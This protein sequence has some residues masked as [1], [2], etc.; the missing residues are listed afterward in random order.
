MLN[1]LL[2]QACPISLGCKSDLTG[3]KPRLPQNKLPFS[4]AIGHRTYYRFFASSLLA[5]TIYARLLC[6]AKPCKKYA[7]KSLVNNAEVSTGVKIIYE[8]ICLK[9]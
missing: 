5:A 2:C 3:L 9:R 6:V 1:V 7:P 4:L 8:K